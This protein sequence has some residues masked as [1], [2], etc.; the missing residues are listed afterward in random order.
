MWLIPLFVE[1][2]AASPRRRK[3]LSNLIV[4]ETHRSCA[5]KEVSFM[6]GSNMRR[7]WARRRGAGEL[8][9]RGRSEQKPLSSMG[10]YESAP[11]LT[12]GPLE[13][14]AHQHP[15]RVLLSPIYSPAYEAMS[16][17]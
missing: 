2:G 1:K 14:P 7:D 17:M 15:A 9:A 10:V 3:E 8:L 5:Y 13:R 16:L 11:P 12:A 4:W 6:T